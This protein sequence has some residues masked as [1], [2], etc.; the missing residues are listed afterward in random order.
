MILRKVNIF[1][2]FFR[3]I[4]LLELLIREIVTNFTLPLSIFSLKCAE[5][6]LFF[7]L[8][9]LI[10]HILLLLFLPAVFLKSAETVRK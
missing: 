4:S 8:S 7:M 2:S 10:V 3:I 6:H 1:L 9:V 5:K